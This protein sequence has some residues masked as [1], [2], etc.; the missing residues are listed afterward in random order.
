[1]SI[2]NTGKVPVSIL[3]TGQNID[4]QETR[5]KNIALYTYIKIND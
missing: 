3:N 4:G 5:P 2:G 1:M